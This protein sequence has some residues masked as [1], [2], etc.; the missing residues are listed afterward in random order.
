M[1]T[2][3]PAPRGPAA[4]GETESPKD[5]GG[6]RCTMLTPGGTARQEVPAPHSRQTPPDVSISEPLSRQG[7]GDNRE[8]TGLRRADSLIRR[9]A[10]CSASCTWAFPAGTGASQRPR[11]QGSPLPASGATARLSRPR[12]S[13][14]GAVCWCARGGG[15]PGSSGWGCGSSP[16][17]TQ[18]QTKGAFLP[19]GFP[20]T[21]CEWG[22]LY[23]AGSH[24]PTETEA[25][26]ARPEPR[27]S[28]PRSRA[29]ALK[30]TGIDPRPCAGRPPRHKAVSSMPN[31]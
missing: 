28:H 7:C 3:G 24:G 18:A 12:Q 4:W 23:A 27:S 13:V 29:G 17:E 14:R 25:T 6:F 30:L 26:G 11:P 10:L 22:A 2:Q 19:P 8:V 20:L 31:A 9:P 16:R 21:G 15:T 1:P 5:M